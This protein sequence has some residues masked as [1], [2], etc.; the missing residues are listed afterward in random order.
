[1]AESPALSRAGKRLGDG[2]AGAAHRVVA[3]L[4]FVHIGLSAAPEPTCRPQSRR[5]GVPPH[6]ALGPGF[7]LC[8]R[9]RHGLCGHGAT[10]LMK[11]LVKDVLWLDGIHDSKKIHFFALLQ[12]A[13]LSSK[14]K[15]V[16]FMCRLF[17][18]TS[19]KNSTA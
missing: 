10:F 15:K 12:E 3:H 9:G 19:S 4:E 5:P 6:P 1:M 2:V 13:A 11:L 16:S 7:L 17:L 18:V 8:P 14:H